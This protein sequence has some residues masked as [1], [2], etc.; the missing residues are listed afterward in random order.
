MEVALWYFFSLEDHPCCL[1]CRHSDGIMYRF[2]YIVEKFFIVC[3]NEVNAIRRINEA[4]S[5]ALALEL[6]LFFTKITEEL[7]QIRF[8]VS[9]HCVILQ[10]ADEERVFNSLL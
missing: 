8:K 1:M 10:F 9:F 3:F 4:V 2:Q 5:S 6:F 7:V